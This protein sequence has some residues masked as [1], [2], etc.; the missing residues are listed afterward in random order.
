MQEVFDFVLAHWELV[1][2]FVLLIT[3]TIIFLLRKRPLNGIAANLYMWCIEAVK[4]AEQE[5][6]GEDAFKPSSSS[7]LASALRWVKVKFEDYYGYNFASY[8]KIAED[9]IEDILSTPQKKEV[10]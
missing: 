5:Y 3:A 2:R 9:Y 8:S 4:Y 1:L 10:K 7:K 6:Y